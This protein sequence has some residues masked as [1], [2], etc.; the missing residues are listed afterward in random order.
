MSMKIDFKDFDAQFKKVV[1][2]KIPDYGRDGMLKALNELLHDA[3]YKQPYAPFDEG[4]LRA[5]ARAEKP[6]VSGDAIIGT[7]GFNIEYAA[8]WH[9]LS[10]AEDKR[11]NWSLPGSGRKFL[12]SKM[13]MF[14]K[15]YLEIIALHIKGLAR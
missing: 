8:R 13:I 7:C 11:I 15:K 9:E 12:E 6:K 3:I 14:A 10:P 4:T 5:S 1:Q 2:G